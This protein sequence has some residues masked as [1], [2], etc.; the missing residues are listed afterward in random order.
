MSVT[1]TTATATTETSGIFAEAV[2]GVATIV[3]AIIALAGTAP[4]FLLAIATIVFGA[5]LLIEGTSIVTDYV[6]VLST[7]DASVGFQGSSGGLAAVFLT[8][9]AGIILGILALLGLHA[10]VLVSAAV[11]AFGAALVLSSSSMFNLFSMKARFMG[12]EMIM[13]GTAA[14]TAGA[15]ALAG[16]AA[17]VLGILAVSG[18]AT[19]PLDLVALLVLGSAILVTGNGMNNAM[20]SMFNRF[21]VRRLS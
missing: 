17:I 12:S 9:L 5:A 21:P 14:S 15:Q 8:G 4:D 10:T 18:V 19:L 3:L 2:G 16:I 1:Q 20:I 7:A 13:G 11:I 6:N